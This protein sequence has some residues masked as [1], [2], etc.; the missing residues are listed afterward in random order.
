MTWMLRVGGWCSL[1][2][3]ILFCFKS[4]IVAVS[5]TLKL[6]SVAQQSRCDGPASVVELI[7]LAALA[8]TLQGLNSC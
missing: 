3:A 4:N 8:R 1:W 6:S 2:Y 7:P 5:N